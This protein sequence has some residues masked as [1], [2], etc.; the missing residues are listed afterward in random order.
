[1]FTSKWNNFNTDSYE[2][3]TFWYKFK[4]NRSKICTDT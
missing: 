3:R 2:S 1:M 4:T